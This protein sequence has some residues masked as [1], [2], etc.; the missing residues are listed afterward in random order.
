[1]FVNNVSLLALPGVVGLSAPPSPANAW[2]V[3][4]LRWI[5]GVLNPCPEHGTG[6]AI[7]GGNL[8]E[9]P[10]YDV[11]ECERGRGTCDVPPPPTSFFERTFSSAL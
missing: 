5:S 8:K 10:S 2:N 1:M 11:D 4:H 3:S 6:Y 7:T 9:D